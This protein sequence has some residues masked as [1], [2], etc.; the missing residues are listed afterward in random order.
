MVDV[1]WCKDA[2]DKKLI[3]EWDHGIMMLE[4]VVYQW[5]QRKLQPLHLITLILISLLLFNKFVAPSPATRYCTYI[6]IPASTTILS[7]CCR[8]V[9][10]AVVDMIT[11][12]MVVAIVLRDLDYVG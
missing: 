2:S 11:V 5:D 6:P 8:S 7:C 10:V 4:R 3:I 1:L 9:T 12:V